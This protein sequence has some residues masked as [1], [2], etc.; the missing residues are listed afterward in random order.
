MSDRLE[1]SFAYKP[2]NSRMIVALKNVE[3]Q[4]A[5][6]R[7]GNVT[8]II[9]NLLGSC[10]YSNVEVYSKLGLFGRPVVDNLNFVQVR[11]ED[12]DE[13]CVLRVRQVEFAILLVFER[14]EEAMREAI[15]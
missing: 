15:R 11:L 14:H 6:D 2:R 12:F 9:A 13:L 10:S 4:N 8:A 1:K 7:K 5:L 3:I